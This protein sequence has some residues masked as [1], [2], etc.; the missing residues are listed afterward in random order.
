MSLFPS[1]AALNR[2]H[3]KH[4]VLAFCLDVE[5]EG[6]RQGVGGWLCA[7]AARAGR[8]V[9]LLPTPPSAAAACVS[10]AKPARA[11]PAGSERANEY[12]FHAHSHSRR[13]LTEFKEARLQLDT[14]IEQSE[15]AVVY[16]SFLYYLPLYSLYVQF[17]HQKKKR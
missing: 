9:A 12:Q 1:P 6:R 17:Y 16:F 7:H 11:A 4:G 14:S 5:N 10:S 2:R 13:R 15:A 8:D 3:P